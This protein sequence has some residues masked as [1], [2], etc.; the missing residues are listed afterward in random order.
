[1][2]ASDKEYKLR[3]DFKKKAFEE[4]R[5]DDKLRT[6]AL[7]QFREWI[8]KHPKIKRCRMDTNFLLRFLRTKKFS[9]PDAV[10]L[11][12]N[13][14][15]TRKLFPQFFDGL[16]LDD[17]VIKHLLTSGCIE[18]LPEPDKQGRVLLTYSREGVDV[19]KHTSTDLIRT[20]NLAYELALLDERAQIYGMAHVINWKDFSVANAKIW[21]IPQMKNFARCMHKTFPLRHALIFNINFT[22]YGVIIW[23]I[24]ASFFSEKLR[25]RV[26]IVDDWK[27]IYDEVGTSAL[28]KEYGGSVPRSEISKKIVELAEKHR[29]EI[30]ALNDFE[31]EISDEDVNF[32]NTHDADLDAAIVGS[33]REIVL[34]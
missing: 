5:E 16:S 10:E 22:K 12:K 30:L 14:L 4:L 19:T 17:P 33:F 32:G 15:T 21:T 34:D 29:D 13:Y 1:M 18:L 9:V 27:T 26:Q 7:A 8:E 6:Q 24:V 3:E 20:M 31:I 23:K 25:K 11:L 2:A 28:P